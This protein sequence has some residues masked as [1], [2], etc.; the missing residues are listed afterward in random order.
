MGDIAL[1]GMCDVVVDVVNNYIDVKVFINCIHV[2]I[3]VIIRYPYIK[4]WI[5][6]VSLLSHILTILKIIENDF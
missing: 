2:I 1:G 5:L 6:F 4:Q 3:A